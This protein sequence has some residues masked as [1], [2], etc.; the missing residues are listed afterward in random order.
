M[1]HGTVQS[2]LKWKSE[3]A[4]VNDLWDLEEHGVMRVVEY[5]ELTGLSRTKATLELKEF[6][7]DTSSGISFVGQ[8]SAKVYVKG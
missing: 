8:G 7:Q 5:M 1:L 6:R 4:M 2:T 3:K